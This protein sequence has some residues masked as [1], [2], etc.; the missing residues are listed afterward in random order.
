MVFTVNRYDERDDMSQI[1]HTNY[2]P[3]PALP[4]TGVQGITG[5]QGITGVTGATGVT[6]GFARRPIRMVSMMSKPK[7]SMFMELIS[8]NIDGSTLIQTTGAE[9]HHNLII[10][11]INNYIYSSSFSLI[12][13]DRY[14]SY[15][16]VTPNFIIGIAKTDKNNEYYFHTTSMYISFNMMGENIFDH[17]P[18]Y[19][20]Y[21]LHNHR[22]VS[23]RHALSEFAVDALYE[24]G[25]KAANGT[26][27]LCEKSIK[28]LYAVCK[29]FGIRNKEVI[30][31]LFL[32]S[33]PR[34][35]FMLLDKRGELE[36]NEDYF[37][38]LLKNNYEEAACTYLTY[39]KTRNDK[40]NNIIIKYPDRIVHYCDMINKPIFTPH[41]L[42]IKNDEITEKYIEYYRQRFHL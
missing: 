2:T 26:T 25:I 21:V 4:V 17:I 34:L 13:T 24:F 12:I 11:R 35:Y 32:K 16:T 28:P 36:Y 22:I 15:D 30:E 42:R 38:Y 23:K 37:D 10:T 41:E 14:T 19:A 33:E 18:E 31:P 39:T 7:P 8:G 9:K 6:G 40:I 5:I 20:G 27:T 1:P 29:E 3:N